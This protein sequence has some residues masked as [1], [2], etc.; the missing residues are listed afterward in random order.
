LKIPLQISNHQLSIK[1][2]K[3]FNSLALSFHKECGPKRAGEAAARAY[4]EV[5][6]KYF[7]EFARLNFPEKEALP[8]RHKDTKKL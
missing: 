1:N 5:A 3:C 6:K 2:Q 4:D 7:G 8:Q